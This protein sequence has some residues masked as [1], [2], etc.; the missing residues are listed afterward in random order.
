M[1]MVYKNIR[2][3]YRRYILTGSIYTGTKITNIF[4]ALIWT[5]MWSCRYF[6]VVEIPLGLKLVDKVPRR[7]VLP[8][9]IHWMSS[10]E[11]S[12]TINMSVVSRELSFKYTSHIFPFK[13]LM[14]RNVNSDDYIYPDQHQM[15]RLEVFL[16]WKICSKW[17]VIWTDHWARTRW[18]C[19]IH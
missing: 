17:R 18:L 3:S 13:F 19:M 4:T 14:R 15:Y 10:L 5:V 2:V 6:T 16:T 12:S 9:K 1:S 7:T 8:I 11:V